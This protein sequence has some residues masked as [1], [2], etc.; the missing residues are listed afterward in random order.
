MPLR[1]SHVGAVLTRSLDHL[2][3]PPNSAASSLVKPFHTSRKLRDDAHGSDNHYETLDLQPDATPAEIKKSF[4]RL[5]KIHHPDVNPS[6]PHA[7]RRFHRISEAYHVL[8][9]AE[10]RARYDRDYFR[11][12]PNHR[13]PKTTPHT[14][15]SS[16]GPAGGRPASGLSSRRRSPFQGPPPSFYRSGGWGSQSS[17]RRA[18]HQESTGSTGSR[19]N[20]ESN[21]GYNNPNPNSSSTG[22]GTGGEAGGQTGTGGMGPGQRPHPQYNWFG[23]TGDAAPHFDKEGHERTHRRADERR[24]TKKRRKGAPGEEGAEEGDWGR[25]MVVSGALVFAMAGP[26]LLIWTWDSFKDWV[27]GGNRRRRKAEGS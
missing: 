3:S 20:P 2:A 13:H 4:Y 10:K 14:Y 21:T 1:Y 23:N 17:K 6:D 5:S 8:S 9:H 15:H 16:G 7:S 24:A 19:Y 18:A 11:R 27:S 26:A 12:H 22:T 25:L